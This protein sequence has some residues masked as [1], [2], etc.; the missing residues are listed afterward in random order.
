MFRP[1]RVRSLDR[2]SYVLEETT[3]SKLTARAFRS[4]TSDHREDPPRSRARPCHKDS[5]SSLKLR[6]LILSADRSHRLPAVQP[7]KHKTEYFKELEQS[8][9]VANHVDELNRQLKTRILGL[10][11]ASCERRMTKRSTRSAQTPS[12]DSL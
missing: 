7:L 5:Q 3:E 1:A 12:G 10:L 9:A 6:T 8:K 4:K 11:V 2:S